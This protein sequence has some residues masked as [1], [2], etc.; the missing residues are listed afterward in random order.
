VWDSYGAEQLSSNILTNP[1]FEPVIDRAV[2]IVTDSDTTGFS[3][4][5]ASLARPDGFWSGATFE[6][7]TGASAGLGG[8]IANSL[9]AAGD[10]LPWFATSGSAPALMPGDVVS[11]TQ[12]QTSGTPYAWSFP[13]S[14][15]GDVAIITTDHRPGSPG[16]SVVE[17][18]LQAAQPTEIFTTFDAQ[19]NNIPGGKFLPVNG[20]WQLSFWARA[21]AGNTTVTAD[22][23]R[24]INNPFLSQSASVS[25]SWQQYTMNFSATDGGPSNPLALS[26]AAIGTA[27]GTV[28]IDDVQ[29]A[30]TSDLPSPW[31]AEVL[32]TLQTL[33]P[34]YLRDLQSQ[35]GDTMTNR[36]APIFGRSPQRWQPDPTNTQATFLY[37]L[38]EFLNLCKFVG[39]Q[40][41][42]VVPTGLYD[43]EFTQ[44]GTYLAQQ[45]STY[46]F[47]EIVVEFGNENWNKM[48][49]G[50]SIPD[51]VT[52]GKAANRGFGLLRAAAG[53]LVPLH[54]VLTGLFVDPSVAQN[55][56]NNAPQ[57]D[58]V[59]IAPYFF[60][61]LNASDTQAAALANM[62][63]TTD[64]LAD[65]PQQRLVTQPLG[66]DIDV[67]EVNL[68]TLN[69]DASA[70]QRNPLASGMV[71]GT[72]LVNR[73][74]AGMSVGLRR[75]MIFSLSQYS[76]PI[77]PALGNVNLFGVTRDLAAAN[78]LR[79]T[80]LAM[81]ML[82]RVIGGD[83]YQVTASGPGSSGLR[84][85][86]FLSPSGWSVVIA[87]S[88][89]TP[90][91]VSIASPAAGAQPTQAFALAAPTMTTDNETGAPVAITSIGLGANLRVTVPAYGLVT[92]NP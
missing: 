10:G 64:E 37:G 12:T 35:L 62:F 66:K 14:S 75:Q 33:H 49:R 42:I 24:D 34:G 46:Q 90:T 56:L 91:A 50:G 70:A 44:L 9:A 16:S 17:L 87:S 2:V 76:D 78:D 30:R 38:P 26:L 22:F 67:H 6:V 81:Q 36:L 23:F 72:A 86:A 74:I 39:A 60:Q 4:N 20:S 29:L 88:N 32:Q 7:R 11:V 57:A 92:L 13:A 48:F 8:T 79:P 15:D 83:Y 63:D 89:P 61:T 77:S 80:G 47:N 52:M 28:R 1:G 31:R 55:A 25:T 51:A 54:L 27:G 40:P 59:D 21:S 71:S 84:A 41:W 19:A 58:A 69:G 82:N 73:L 85:A 68:Q 45:Q 43:A 18:T 53:P 65:I 3:D 5:D